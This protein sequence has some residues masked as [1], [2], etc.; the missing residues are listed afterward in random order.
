MVRKIFFLPGY[1]P[2][3]AFNAGGKEKVNGGR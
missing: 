3:T 2:L 1:K